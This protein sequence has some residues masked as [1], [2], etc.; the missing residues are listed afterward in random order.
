MITDSTV[1]HLFALLFTC[2]AG[3]TFAIQ[4]VTNR[5]QSVKLLSIITSITSG[6]FATYL[7]LSITPDEAKEVFWIII[8]HTLYVV[9]FLFSIAYGVMAIISKYRADP[10]WQ[11]QR[12]IALWT[13][14]CGLLYILWYFDIR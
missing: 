11:S 10:E 12:N 6:G 5:D 1:L 7:Y 4:A 2:I 14:T 9:A 3:V 13:L 8:G